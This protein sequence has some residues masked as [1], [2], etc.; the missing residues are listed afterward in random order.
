MPDSLFMFRAS[1]YVATL[2]PTPPERK[3]ASTLPPPFFLSKQIVKCTFTCTAY[4]P[5]LRTKYTY[6]PAPSP[7]PSPAPPSLSPPQQG[8]GRI[9][10]RMRYTDPN[11]ETS[12]EEASGGQGSDA[13]AENGTA[14]GETL[15]HTCACTHHSTARTHHSTTR[16]D[17]QDNCS[18]RTRVKARS[19]TSV[20]L[21]LS[22]V[23]QS[24]FCGKIVVA[25]ALPAA[26][27]VL[28]AS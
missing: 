6:K 14:A 10:L 8:E 26:R 9:Q 7:F 25:F 2:A 3:P 19:V 24:C 28:V 20:V 18:I 1:M 13:A 21:R 11:P 27:G 4:L 12:S 5:Q 15:C 23:Q 16:T 22:A 17:L